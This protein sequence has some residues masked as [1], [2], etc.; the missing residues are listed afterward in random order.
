MTTKINPLTKQETEIE[1]AKAMSRLGAIT[2]TIARDQ[3]EDAL[4]TEA[5][6]WAAMI[7]IYLDSMAQQEGGEKAVQM[8][9]NLTEKV[10]DRTRAVME[11]GEDEA[12]SARGE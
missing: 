5:L 9:E 7:T 8:F 12:R 3:D 10:V 1:V 4:F 11:H 6:A 2:S